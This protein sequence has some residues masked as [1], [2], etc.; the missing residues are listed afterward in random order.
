MKAYTPEQVNELLEQKDELLKA[1]DQIIESYRDQ[2]KN[3]K[4][5]I[6]CLREGK[7]AP[8]T[9]Q[10]P[11]NNNKPVEAKIPPI[12]DQKTGKYRQMNKQEEADYVGTLNEVI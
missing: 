3:L 1:K 8:I 12:L 5:A 10:I 6:E 9:T 11:M 7:N 2:V 4:Y